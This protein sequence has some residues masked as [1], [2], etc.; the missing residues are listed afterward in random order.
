MIRLPHRPEAATKA[1]GFV[2][3][4]LRSWAAEPAVPAAELIATEL[5]TNAVRHAEGEIEVELSKIGD[6]LHI[7]VADQ[8]PQR[9]PL[10]RAI[11]AGSTSGYG[12]HLIEQFGKCWGCVQAQDHK[13]V[14]ADIDINA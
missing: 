14:W 8:T 12:L 11:P 2:R 5:V 3:T 6:T 4:I 13:T 10:R 9:Q 1:R 7:A